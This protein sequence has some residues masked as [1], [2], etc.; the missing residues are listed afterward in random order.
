MKRTCV[1][2]FIAQAA[3]VCLTNREQVNEADTYSIP[4]AY[5][6]VNGDIAIACNIEDFNA[7]DLVNGAC[8]CVVGIC[9]ATF[10][11]VDADFDQITNFSYTITDAAFQVSEAQEVLLRV[12][13]IDDEPAIDGFEDDELID[14]DEDIES[15]IVEF[16]YSDPEN[17][18]ATRCSVLP[19]DDEDLAPIFRSK[20]TIVENRCECINESTCQFMAK[21]VKNY[22]GEIHF[23]LV[24]EA[25]GALSQ[26]MRKKITINDVPDDPYFCVFSNSAHCADNNCIGDV[27]PLG[28]FSADT[29]NEIKDNFNP[30]EPIIYL[31]QETGECFRPIK[32]ADGEIQFLGSFSDEIL[33]ES[34]ISQVAGGDRPG[35]FTDF[36][37]GVRVISI[38]EGGN[39]DDIA[40]RGRVD[41]DDNDNLYDA[42]GDG[43]GDQNYVLAGSTRR[44]EVENAI[45]NCM[46]RDDTGAAAA[47][48]PTNIECDY[49]LA[50][51]KLNDNF[52]ADTTTV[53]N[54]ILNDDDNK[55]DQGELTPSMRF[56]AKNIGSL[57][58]SFEGPLC[59]RFVHGARDGQA[60]VHVLR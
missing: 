31:N 35:V 11:A 27:D 23:N 29:I 17:D 37:F 9:T 14:F 59:V 7:I 16:N 57:K 10:D 2:T 40:L 52:L 54:T 53:S 34:G 42:P 22:H 44:A 12:N 36:P 15:N 49:S 1:S 26:P 33:F 8:N 51:V 43:I 41:V 48:D 28:F 3:P 6:D 32:S 55:H 24:V 58:D 4:L 25:N 56:R 13:P 20:L 60:R 18:R 38:P 47:V 50:G 19:P 39:E 5:S 46:D 21:V 30:R 45:R